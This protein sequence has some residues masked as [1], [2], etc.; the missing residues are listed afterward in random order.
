MRYARPIAAATRPRAGLRGPSPCALSQIPPN[1][2]RTAP[3]PLN[4]V[5]LSRKTARIQGFSAIER[6]AA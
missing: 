2:T 4:F 6:G 3:I 5:K 1:F